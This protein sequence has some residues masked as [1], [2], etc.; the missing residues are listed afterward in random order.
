MPDRIS[1]LMFRFLHQIEGRLSKRAQENEF[2]DL[3]QIEIEGI[4]RLY[5]DGFGEP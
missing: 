2:K 3:T 4:E 5:A 1:D